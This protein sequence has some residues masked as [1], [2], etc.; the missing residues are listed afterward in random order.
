MEE[1]I[2]NKFN[3]DVSMSSQGSTTNKTNKTPKTN[4][5]F[6]KPVKKTSKSQFKRAAN[7]AKKLNLRKSRGSK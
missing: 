6:L 4:K 1:R 3:L 2:V 7:A 5:V